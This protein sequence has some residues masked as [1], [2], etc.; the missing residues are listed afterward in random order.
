MALTKKGKML[1]FAPDE[2]QYAD[3]N[4]GKFLL[5]DPNNPTQKT[6]RSLSRNPFCA[7]HC[8]LPDGR[9]LVAAGQSTVAAQF[10][11]SHIL[12][13]IKSVLGLVLSYLGIL[14]IFVRGADHDIHTFDTDAESWTRHRGMPRARWYPTCVTLPDGR[15]L[16][17][18]GQYSQGHSLCNK[19][20]EIF[21]PTTN[22]L[23]E[24]RHFHEEVHVYPF[25]QVLPGGTLFVHSKDTTRLLNLN[26]P[27]ESWWYTQQFNLQGSGT[28]TYPGAGACVLLP[29]TADETR[30]RVLIVGGSTELS[31][32]NETPAT[33]AA[34]IFEFN[35]QNPGESGWKK[36]TSMHNQ[37]FMSEAVILP[38]GTIMMVGGAS[39]GTATHSEDAVKDVELFDPNATPPTWSTIGQIERARLYHSSALLL[40]DG[41][42]FVAGST[43]HKWPPSKLEMNIEVL[44]PPYWD[45]PRPVINHAPSQASYSETFAIESPDAQDVESVAL[46][47][48][49]SDTHTNNM[50]QRYVELTILDRGNTRLR[51]KAPKDATFA[52]PS[53]YMLFL[54]NSR[55]VPSV[56]KFIQIGTFQ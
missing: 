38:D 56:A 22:S 12:Y 35:P 14:Q 48:P 5:W 42:V 25:L 37:R 27:A 24:P 19:K 41:R 40:S 6:I 55:K 20:F 54:L 10:T 8:F 17:V 33:D 23:T 21:D 45:K 18:S 36:T 29:L 30:A 51:V 9:L 2:E 53:F 44:S 26:A 28:R 46:I 3:I 50:D 43:G 31:P 39:K 16:I 52:P 4:R 13:S 49:S 7:G 47:R 15:A 32:K 1:I 11:S 34:E